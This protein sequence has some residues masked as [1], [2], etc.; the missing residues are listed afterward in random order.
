ML[1]RCAAPLVFVFL[2]FVLDV[3]A[4]ADIYR[5]RDAQGVMHFSNQ[6]PPQGVRV[7]ER[8]EETPHDPAADRERRDS[9]QRVLED[10]ERRELEEQKRRALEREREA[11]RRI[12]EAERRLEEAQRIEERARRATPDDC[13]R[14]WFL[15]YGSCEGFVVSPPVR[16]V[17]IHGRP[18]R[19][20]ECRDW[21][22]EN[23]SIY[24]REPE[25]PRPPP[26]PPPRPPRA[27]PSKD[28]GGSKPP[29]A[30]GTNPPPEEAAAGSNPRR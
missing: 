5:W 17:I 19:P 11:R 1:H 24:C 22:R 3:T 18:P 16:R 14:D 9:E 20:D 26:G 7:L 23:N 27:A 15:R 10:F 13:D 6:P 2:F 21:Y 4:R 12:E 25:K 8:I 30:R 29:S 28:P